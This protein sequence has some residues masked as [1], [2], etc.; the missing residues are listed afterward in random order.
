MS[1]KCYVSA[2]EIFRSKRGKVS[3]ILG[4]PAEFTF[5]AQFQPKLAMRV[6]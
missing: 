1:V 4:M 5:L 6:R 2:R 3:G